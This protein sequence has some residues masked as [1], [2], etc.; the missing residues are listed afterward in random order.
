MKMKGVEDV[1]DVPGGKL[2]CG[3]GYRAHGH[4][5]WEEVDKL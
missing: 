3:N 2:L 5:N 1:V 4:Y